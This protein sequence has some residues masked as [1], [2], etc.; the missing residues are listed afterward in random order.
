M[1]MVGGCITI[2]DWQDHQPTYPVPIP[3]PDPV[4]DPAPADPDLE[5]VTWIYG[6][7]ISQWP[8]TIKLTNV[9]RVGGN[10]H[11]DYDRLQ[12]IPAADNVPNPADVNGN[13][14]LVRWFNGIKY[15]GTF[16]WLTRGK[17]WVGFGPAPKYQFDPKPGDRYGIMVSTMARNECDGTVAGGVTYRERSN[18]V[19]LTW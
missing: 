9:R 14:W 2:P 1:V 13:V 5:G 4:P 11:F 15:C 6:R 18:V 8:K 17:L 19:W 12:D 10:I 3:T 7:N 16:E